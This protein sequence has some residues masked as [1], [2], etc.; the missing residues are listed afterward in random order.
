MFNWKIESILVKPEENG[1]TDVV[2][3]VHWRCSANDENNQYGVC[4]GN[5]TFVVGE[6]FTAFQDLTQEQIID[7]C[8]ANGVDK[9]GVE[10]IVT[11]S[12]TNKMTV[13]TLESKLLPWQNN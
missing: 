10:A 3:M 6:T 1:R 13:S 12:L 11:K 9:A 5:M 7:W 8:F 2:A 4:Y